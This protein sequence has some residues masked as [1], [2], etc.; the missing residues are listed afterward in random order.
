MERMPGRDRNSGRGNE[1]RARQG[2]TLL[3]VMF[4]ISIFIA[5]I[6]CAVSALMNTIR[7]NRLMTANATANAAIL[8]QKEEIQEIAASG[9]DAPAAASVRHCPGSLSITVKKQIKNQI[10]GELQNDAGNASGYSC[11]AGRRPG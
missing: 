11:H 7:A 5:A 1:R 10:A 8:R 6:L 2:M 4:A 3:E 9:G